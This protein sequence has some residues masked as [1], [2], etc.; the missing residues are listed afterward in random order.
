MR[1]DE[2]GQHGVTDGFV[3]TPQ[4]AG[5]LQGQPQARHLEKFSADTPHEILD[6]SA[7]I[8]HSCPRFDV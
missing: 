2:R 5:L 1:V 8:F 3:Q 4:P 6:A 7:G